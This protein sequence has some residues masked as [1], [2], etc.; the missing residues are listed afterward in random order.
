MAP[1]SDCSAIALLK[2][3]NGAISDTGM[4]QKD[5]KQAEKIVDENQNEVA[6]QMTEEERVEQACDVRAR[7]VNEINER[8]RKIVQK[9]FRHLNT[10]LNVLVLGESESGKIDF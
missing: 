7:K 8:S 1:R 2:S 9:I 4:V 10:N 6:P 3:S 5:L